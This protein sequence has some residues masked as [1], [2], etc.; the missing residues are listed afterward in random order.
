MSP[1]PRKTYSVG[2]KL[3][4]IDEAKERTEN[5]DSLRAI[6][7]ELMVDSTQLQRWIKQADQIRENVKTKGSGLSLTLH[8]GRLSCLKHIEDDLLMFIFECR[9]QGMSVSI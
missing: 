1:P 9:E 4:M 5:G 2:R 7:R 8:A 3:R 6:A